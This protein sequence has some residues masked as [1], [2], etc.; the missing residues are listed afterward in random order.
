[1]KNIKSIK[2]FSINENENIDKKQILK[3]INNLFIGI[4]SDLQYK[5]YRGGIDDLSS[6]A[7]DEIE[8]YL[9]ECADRIAETIADAG[10]STLREPWCSRDFTDSDEDPNS[11]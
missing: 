7:L 5:N 8:S 9:I 2:D 4:E 3:R 1:M 10:G 6:E 11:I